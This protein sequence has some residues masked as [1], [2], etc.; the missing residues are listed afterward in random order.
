MTFTGDD[1]YTEHGGRRSGMMLIRQTNRHE[2]WNEDET[3]AIHFIAALVTALVLA[4]ILISIQRWVD[5]TR[6]EQKAQ[7]SKAVRKEVF[8]TPIDPSVL[9]DA[10]QMR[11]ERALGLSATREQMSAKVLALEGEERTSAQRSIA[12]VI[13]QPAT[14]PLDRQIDLAFTR[15]DAVRD[16]VGLPR[17]GAQAQ[18]E[19]HPR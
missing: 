16:F 4:G 11:V 3:G 5:G 9:L 6:A 13:K 10:E 7:Y 1:A 2:Q 18:E 19:L 8:E 12:R 14:I 17:E 15:W